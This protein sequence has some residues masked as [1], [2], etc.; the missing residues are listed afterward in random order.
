VGFFSG[1]GDTPDVDPLS[2]LLAVGVVVYPFLFAYAYRDYRR[3][4]RSRAGF[5]KNVGVGG[6]GFAILLQQAASRWLTGVAAGAV[7][8][9]SVG[10]LAV[11]AWALYR[12]YVAGVPEAADA[13]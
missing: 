13:E 9:A 1:G 7:A 12:V 4:G 11:G 6:P 3:G 2:W 10:P 5:L 8:V